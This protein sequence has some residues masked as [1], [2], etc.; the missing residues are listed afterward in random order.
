MRQSRR[1]LLPDDHPV[2]S[3]FGRAFQRIA[4]PG[5]FTQPKPLLSI[6]GPLPQH[7]RV[8][9]RSWLVLCLLAA[10]CAG[11]VGADGAWRSDDGVEVD[12]GAL[13][14]FA[15]DDH[16]EWGD[17][18]F[19][20]IGRTGQVPGIPDGFR[21]QYV[22]DPRDRLDQVAGA[23]IA[24]VTPPADASFSGYST[25]TAELWLAFS[26]EDAVY[27]RVRGEFE[28]WPRVLSAEPILCV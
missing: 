5:N 6:A 24:D 19:L 16:C 10:A 12:T 26:N 8:W 4:N 13:W 28:Q 21:G 3:R 27:V 22:R 15:G 23:F 18:T 1:L 25:P 7:G 11:P 14:S 20:F 2:T 9:I 17:V